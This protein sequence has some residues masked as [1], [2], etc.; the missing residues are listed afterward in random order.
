MKRGFRLAFALVVAALSLATGSGLAQQQSGRDGVSP[1]VMLAH[2]ESPSA[3]GTSIPREHRQ[4]Q[5]PPVT[6]VNLDARLNVSPASPVVCTT[7]PTLSADIIGVPE[8]PSAAEPLLTLVEFKTYRIK[9]GDWPKR[10][11][12]SRVGLQRNWQWKPP[13]AGFFKLEVIVKV[14]S[15]Q[16]LNHPIAWVSRN[17][18]PYVVNP[19]LNLKVTPDS[20][21][22]GSQATVTAS[23]TC[24]M[25]RAPVSYAFSLVKV[26]AAS[27]IATRPVSS[28]PNWTVTLPD[29]PGTYTFVVETMNGMAPN[30]LRVE[31][32]LE[33]SVAQ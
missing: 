20:G 3:P 12:A 15:R 5:A 14:V 13:S 2:E 23:L 11:G 6:G 32:R 22:V 8:A 33:Y 17:I 7:E 27:P 16:A 10:A 24:P 25:P 9:T 30:E 31:N 21:R 29:T 4:P 26:D 18:D 19:S 28:D 1:R